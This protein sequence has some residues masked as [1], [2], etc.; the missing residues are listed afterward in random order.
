MV[1]VGG[2]EKNTKYVKKHKFDEIR[3]KFTKVWGEET[4]SETGGNE[5]K[6]FKND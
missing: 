5:L 1:K 4:F 6:Q 2:K 3:G